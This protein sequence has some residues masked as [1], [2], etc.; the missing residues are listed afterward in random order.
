[1]SGFPLPD[2]ARGL[3]GE[4]P[5]PDRSWSLID[6]RE[7]TLVCE[8]V[9][10]ANQDPG[11]VGTD[12]RKKLG[13]DQR[14]MRQTVVEAWH[15]D[16]P[17]LRTQKIIDTEVLLDSLPVPTPGEAADLIPVPLITGR[18]GSGKS[19][20]LKQIV[21][22]AIALS[23]WDR[24]LAI[25]YGSALSNPYLASSRLGISS[26]SLS[27]VHLRLPGRL[28]DKELF[29]RLCKKVGTIPGSDPRDAF[30][31]AILRNGIRTVALDEIQFI[32]F[33]GQ[34]GKYVHDALKNI[35]NLGVRLIM[36]GHNMREQLGEQNTPA[37]QG[38]LWQSE[39]RWDWVDITR[40]GHS[41][42][43]ERRQ[44]KWLLE[45]VEARLRLG[46]HEP[47]EP[48]LSIEFEEYLWVRT[49]GYMNHLS[50]LVIRAC[51]TAAKTP[52]ERVT[53]QILDAMTAGARAEKGRRVRIQLWEAGR[54]N[55]GSDFDRSL[56]VDA[57]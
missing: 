37:R 39:A 10:A 44:W 26:H 29:E 28:R 43:L 50:A 3:F 41:T 54:F 27:V 45:Q 18:P 16:W 36:S 5:E 38:A 8:I 22:R 42:K 55:W 24:R 20:L 1:V 51:V 9:F 56:D 2:A 13:P 17:F 32:N 19:K 14:R 31:Q 11:L 35:Q 15:R 46:G 53:R 47:S 21:A 12:E 30:E 40:Y 34:H 33:D 25:D 57:D 4:D 52:S 6:I 48:V 7:K 49:L 23:A